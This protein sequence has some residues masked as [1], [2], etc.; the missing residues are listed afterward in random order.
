MSQQDVS[1]LSSSSVG[2]CQ[3]NGNRS[4]QESKLD[5]LATREC[6]VKIDEGYQKIKIVRSNRQS[7]LRDSC[8]SLFSL[9]RHHPSQRLI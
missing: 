3:D 8:Q 9:S 5:F 1:D 6:L 2:W 4:N 7:N